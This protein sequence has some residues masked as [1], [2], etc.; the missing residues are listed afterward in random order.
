MNWFDRVWDGMLALLSL[1]GIDLLCPLSGTL[2][3]YQFDPQSKLD[4]RQ[5]LPSRVDKGHHGEIS[6]CSM[7]EDVA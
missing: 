6:T 3:E 2:E 5:Q 7:V 1:R 4:L